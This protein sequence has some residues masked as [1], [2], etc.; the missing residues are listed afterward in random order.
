MSEMRIRKGDKVRV[1]SGKDR[2]AEGV[3]IKALPR[4]RRVVVEGVA[5]VKKAV[6]P[7]QANPRGGIIT[8][9]ASIDVSNVMLIDPK[10]GEPTRV[11]MKLDEHGKVVRNA[12]GN[13]VRVSKKSGAEF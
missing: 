13:V 5:Q 4:E 8:K 7:T 1:I 10:S 9:E 6:R 11:S 12:K 2:G 3:V